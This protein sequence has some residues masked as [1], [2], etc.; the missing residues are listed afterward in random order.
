MQSL[1]PHQSS[2]ESEGAFQW[3]PQVKCLK[4]IALEHPPHLEHKLIAIIYIVYKKKL[5]SR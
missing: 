5:V 3:Y 1:R 4:F 2:P